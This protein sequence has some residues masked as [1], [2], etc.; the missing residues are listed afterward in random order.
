MADAAEVITGAA[1]DWLA[2]NREALN[3]RFLVARRRFPKL[4]P[5][6]VLTLCREL[7]PPLASG[8][9]DGSSELLSGIYDL[10]LLHAGRGTLA[11]GGG[12]LP[13]IGILLR[14]TLPRLRRLLL[15]QPRDLAPALSNAVENLGP[16]GL[17]FA[18]TLAAMADL[19][20]D[21]EVLY[22]AGVV[23]AWRLGEARLRTQALARVRGLPPR[24]ALM[25][26]G[27]VDWPEQAAPLV[28]AGLSADGWC[29]PEKLLAGSTLAGLA[30][31]Q[32]DRV[33]ALVQQMAARPL[34]GA[35]AWA[36]AG[37]LGNFVGFDGHFEQPPLLLDA[38]SQSSRH[39][40]WVQSGASR[41]RI[42]ADVFG[43]VCRPDPAADY[44]VHRGEVLQ[45][46][47]PAGTTSWIAF[48][49]ALA[50][51]LAD[52]FRI[53]ILTPSRKPL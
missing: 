5:R 46:S 25:A 3:E 52:S 24:V 18:G 20:P 14:E 7:L 40:Y 38:G 33:Q 49:D 27:L 13:G 29:P 16:H 30:N 42:D 41:Y 35:S 17:E 45:V 12:S 31:Q 26:L 39:R 10:I 15:M 34:E 2:V 11:P 23:Q 21:V 36:L 44:P 28:H 22:D 51:T 9:E 1:R 37:R 53:R 47:V 48:D 43:W 8:G 6:A 19:L 50:Y 4:D 32:P